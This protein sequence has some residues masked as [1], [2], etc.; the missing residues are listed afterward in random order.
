MNEGTDMTEDMQKNEQECSGLASLYHKI[1][2]LRKDLVP[3][4]WAKDKRVVLGRDS[5]PYLPTDK[6]L[7]NIAPFVAKNGLD[8]NI[9]DDVPVSLPP[10]GNKESHWMIRVTFSL[11]DMDTGLRDVC[12]VYGEATDNG[13]KGLRSAHTM[14]LRQWLL[15]KFMIS[16]GMDEIISPGDGG[17]FKPKTPEEQEEAKSKVLA[18]GERPS[19]PAEKKTAENGMVSASK[20]KAADTPS[21]PAKAQKDGD[22]PFTPVQRDKPSKAPAGTMRGV[23]IN[24]FVSSLSIPKFKRIEKTLGDRMALHEKGQMTDDDYDRM[25]DQLGM[26]D[27]VGAADEFVGLYKVA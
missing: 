3:L 16:D 15:V 19:K 9:V 2:Q 5:Y 1:N 4:D 25:I 26:I 27:S 23:P 22:S 12:V 18:M 10:V 14:A 7:R 8:L 17:T 24:A 6:L 21:E 13:D 20:E 11:I